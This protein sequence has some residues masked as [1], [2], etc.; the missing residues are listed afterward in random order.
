MRRKLLVVFGVMAALSF[1]GLP[2]AFAVFLWTV[3]IPFMQHIQ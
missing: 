1:T 3:A 2:A